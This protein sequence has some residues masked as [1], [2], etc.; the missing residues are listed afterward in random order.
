MKITKKVSHT[1]LAT[2]LCLLL[3]PAV[4][5]GGQAIS[6]IHEAELMADSALIRSSRKSATAVSDSLKAAADTVP[7]KRNFITRIVDYFKESNKK[8]EYKGFDFSIIGGPHSS[9]CLFTAT[10]RLWAS[11]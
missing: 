10:C 11:I 5:S 9:T 3:F 8:K 2:M 7:V 6:D 4:R 1:L